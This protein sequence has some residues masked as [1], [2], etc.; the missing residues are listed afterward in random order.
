MIATA[1]D[2]VPMP[3]LAAVAARAATGRTP[4]EVRRF[5]TGAAHYVFEALFDDG[6]P[7]L[8]CEWVRQRRGRAWPPGFV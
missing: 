3:A 2:A 1:Q 4:V 7:L 8:S 5:R 6:R